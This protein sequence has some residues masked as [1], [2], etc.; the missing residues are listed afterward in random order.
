[1]YAMSNTNDI[2]RQ[3]TKLQD[4]IDSLHHRMDRFYS[5]AGLLQQEFRNIKQRIGFIEGMVQEKFDFTQNQPPLAS[6]KG[7]E[8]CFG[9][10]DD[11][12]LWAR[13]MRI[14]GKDAED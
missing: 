4:S 12:A 14:T 11:N 2:E 6:Q 10:D 5:W 8:K 13:M 1:M 9:G 3:L 7:S